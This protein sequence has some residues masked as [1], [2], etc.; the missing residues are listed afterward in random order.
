MPPGPPPPRLAAYDTLSPT[1]V[2]RLRQLS[3]QP[4]QREA[5]GSVEAALDWL[6]NAPGESVSGWV[7]LV[8]GWPA[9]FLLLL[10]AP[11]APHWAPAGAAVVHALQ[12]DHRAQRQ[13]VGTACLRALPAAVRQRWPEVSH[14]ALGV[15]P[16]NAAALAFYRELGWVEAGHGCRARVGYERRFTLALGPGFNLQTG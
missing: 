5:C 2:S 10:R 14:L 1:Q 11:C 12:V 15:D 6:S 4:C 7:L 13:G 9:A 3:V 16:G 8:S